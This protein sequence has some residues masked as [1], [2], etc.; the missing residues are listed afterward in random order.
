MY[1][2]PNFERITIPCYVST[3]S[4]SRIVQHF[5]A[6]EL[7]DAAKAELL[8]HK[9][10]LDKRA[11]YAEAEEALGA[12]DTLLK[13]RRDKS[14]EEKPTTLLDAAIFAYAYLL[15]EMEEDYWEDRGLR[16]MVSG[17]EG[18]RWLVDVVR[19]GYFRARPPAVWRRSKTVDS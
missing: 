2:T 8:K 10:I 9:P 6:R 4:T 1:L 19:K 16:D 15:L 7:Q 5:N 18:L 17:C 11:I 12:L 14:P 13:N 3:T